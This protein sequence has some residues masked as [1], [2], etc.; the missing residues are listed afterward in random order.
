MRTTL[1]SVA[2]A[3]LLSGALRAQAPA[4]T[5]KPAEVEKALLGKWEGPYQSDQ[6]PP[7]SL[8]LLV[9]KEAGAWKVSLQVISDQ[10][11]PAGDVKEFKVVGKTVSWDQEISGLLCHASAELVNGTLTGGSQ[12]EQ[13]GAVTITASWVLLKV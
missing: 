1:L 10:E 4:P 12:C 8:R 7:G 13:G 11:L 2:A 6:A 3:A 9:A 5:P